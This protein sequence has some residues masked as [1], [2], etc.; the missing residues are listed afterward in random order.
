VLL[1]PSDQRG[2]VLT[3]TDPR[4]GQFFENWPIGTLSAGRQ[5][6]CS[7]YPRRNS[8]EG[9]GEGL[10]VEPMHITLLIRTYHCPY[11]NR[12]DIL[13]CSATHAEQ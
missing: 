5:G 11:R 8:G 6:R 2:G 13:T 12:L 10:E 9:G 1:T 3:L 7:V 4:G